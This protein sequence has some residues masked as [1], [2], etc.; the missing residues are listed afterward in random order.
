MTFEKKMIFFFKCHFYPPTH[1]QKVSNDMPASILQ[2]HPEDT[3]ITALQPLTKG[4]KI[5]LNGSYVELAEDIPIKHKFTRRALQPGDPATM[6]G[7]LVGKATQ[8]IPAGGWIYTHNFTHASDAFDH[9]K[10]TGYRWSPPDVSKWTGRTF[11]GYH[12]ADGS[13]GTA[14]YWLVIPL[15]FCENRNLRV[16]REALLEPLG[17]ATERD[18]SMDVSALVNA[19]RA[20]ESRDNL[21]KTNILRSGEDIRQQR[22]F[23]N[24]DG[25]KFLLHDG[26]CGCARQDSDALC[27]LFAGYIANPNV[28]GATVLSLGCQHSQINILQE[29]LAELYPDCHKPVHYLEHQKS[30]SERALIE[31]AIKLTFMGLTEANEIRRQPAP[32]SAL[33]L[34][35]KCGGSDGFSGLSANP[36]LGHASDLLVALGGKSLLPEFPE[37]CGVEQALINRCVSADLGEKFARLMHDYNAQ[38]EALGSGFKA[39]PSPGNIRDGLIT[40]AIKSAGAARKGGAAP[41]SDV[42][43]YTEPAR[44]PGL[45]LLCTPGNDVEAMTA[46]AASGA[47]VMVFTTGLGTPTGNP[48]VPV[49]KFATNDDLYR[50]M[51]DILDLNAGDIITGEC[52]IEEK[53]EELLEL[54]I[55]VASGE[56]TPHA[57]RLGQDDFIPWKRGV[58]L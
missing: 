35:L 7:V 9:S 57:V 20:G 53:G 27:R 14:N 41:I 34:G 3:L 24:V 10:Y 49:I 8:A 33:T 36:A 4:Q 13:V 21:L 18:F 23:P 22:I 30:G 28:A 54:M 44:T 47:N 31:E 52:S 26:G 39:N 6:Y 48:I 1:E 42:L 11:E 16:I 38:A 55:R 17:Y 58:S 2:I 43:N 56:V 46:L 32:L 15:V 12:R 5:A 19:W 50:R 51:G 25:I 40:D 37:L 29:A 45:A